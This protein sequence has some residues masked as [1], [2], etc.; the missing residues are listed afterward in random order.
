MFQCIYLHF[1]FRAVTG[2]YPQAFD[3]PFPCVAVGSVGE[4]LSSREPCNRPQSS[5]AS[6]Q[7]YIHF[8]WAVV[9]P[10]DPD[11]GPKHMEIEAT[12]HKCQSGLNDN[13]E[14]DGIFIKQYVD[15]SERNSAETHTH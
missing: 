13:I 8:L 15:L 5:Q 4:L 3:S 2:T 9:D 11:Q 1:I 12:A 10:K 14:K 7:I 6:P